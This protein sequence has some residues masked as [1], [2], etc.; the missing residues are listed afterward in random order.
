MDSARTMTGGWPVYSLYGLTL[1]S[2]FPFAN[3]LP[4]GAGPPDLTFS[5]ADAPPVTGWEE[6]PS[7]YASPSRLDG[8]ESLIYVYRQDDFHVLRFT[9]VA[10]FYLW[11][12][13]IVCHLLDP[14]YDYVVEIYL[15]GIA[16]SLWLELRGIPAL[17]AS[18]VVVEDR[19]VA[20]LATN[21]GGKSSLAATLMQVGYPLLTDDIL[22]IERH[23]ET[24]EGRPGYPQMRMWPDQAR[25]FLGYYED[26]AIVHP[27]YSKRRV[28][29]GEDGLGTFRDE[30]RPLACFYLPERRDPVEWG[31]GTEFVPV[32]RVEGLMTL[33]RQS[34]VPNTVEALGLQPQRLG[35]FAPLVSQIPVR[36][37]VYP[38]GYD[39]LP[40]VRRAILADLPAAR[41]SA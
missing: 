14:A 35:F 6:R 36:R 7:V 39:H 5:L 34:F 41:R 27:A 10:D 4:E 22:P 12:Q 13:D 20:F 26:L 30:P 18:A 16:F 38:D 28:P 37:V 15:L 8:G 2:D 19:A 24:F 1:A 25:H 3:R 32:P 23:K 17:H 21:S 31:T 29:V 33:V 9:E 40:E 11:P